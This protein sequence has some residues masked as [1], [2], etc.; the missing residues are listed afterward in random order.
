MVIM[1]KAKEKEEFVDTVTVGHPQ[2]PCVRAAALQ[3]RSGTRQCHRCIYNPA[4]SRGLRS[5][6]LVIPPH[7]AAAGQPFFLPNHPGQPR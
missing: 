5:T 4:Q 6:L 7:G 3:G 1:R 2:R